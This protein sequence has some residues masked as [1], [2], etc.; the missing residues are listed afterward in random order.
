MERAFSI[1]GRAPRSHRSLES[2]YRLPRELV[3]MAEAY[4]ARHWDLPYL[5][6]R[7]LVLEERAVLRRL[8]YELDPD[9]TDWLHKRVR[10]LRSERDQ[11]RRGNG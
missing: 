7:E 3:N 5:T 8:D 10:A 1:G 6:D 2:V 11:R 4:R 9:A